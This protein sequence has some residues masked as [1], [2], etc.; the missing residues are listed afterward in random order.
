MVSM[1]VLIRTFS[2]GYLREEEEHKPDPWR[3]PIERNHMRL[4][5]VSEVEVVKTPTIISNNPV[6]WKHNHV[7]NPL[8][9]SK[10]KQQN[11]STEKYVLRL[12]REK[13]CRLIHFG[14]G[15]EMLYTLIRSSASVVPTSSIHHD[16]RLLRSIYK[17]TRH[18]PR[19]KVHT[20]H[21]KDL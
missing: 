9:H 10:T 16:E 19:N 8:K 20:S 21:G 14:G 4:H 1:A 13:A 6:Q 5:L 11:W 17:T 15:F 3:N 12:D 2:S 18:H 7:M